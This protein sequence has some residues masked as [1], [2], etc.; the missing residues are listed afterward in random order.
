MTARMRVWRVNL[1]T[2][3][4]TCVLLRKNWHS[5]LIWR[6]PWVHEGYIPMKVILLCSQKSL[7]GSLGEK[8]T[9]NQKEHPIETEE[10]QPRVRVRLYQPIA[11]TLTSR[12][13]TGLHAVGMSSQITDSQLPSHLFLF[14][15]AQSWLHPVSVRNL[16]KAAPSPV[17]CIEITGLSPPVFAGVGE[18]CVSSKLCSFAYPNHDNHTTGVAA[19]DQ[20]FSAFSL[21]FFCT[22][23][24]HQHYSPNFSILSQS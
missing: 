9:P 12:Q 20:V 21:S 11:V 6:V 15:S 18:F 17:G 23:G 4:Q 10:F 13:N 22:P 8:R 19:A 16:D 5:A 2:D 24:Q 7:I 1:S 14:L 3:V